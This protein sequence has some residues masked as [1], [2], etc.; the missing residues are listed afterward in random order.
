[1]GKNTMQRQNFI[2][3]NLVIEEDEPEEEEE[4]LSS[5]STEGESGI[6]ETE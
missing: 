6:S 4:S 2:I 1:M 5:P 3:N